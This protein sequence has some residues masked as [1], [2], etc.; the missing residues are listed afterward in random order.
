MNKISVTAHAG[1]KGEETPK[2]FSLKDEKIHVVEILERWIEEG[3]YS[4]LRK[5]YFKVKGSDGN[6]F[7]L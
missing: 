2:A 4:R 1:Y 7:F 3:I 6:K 5:R